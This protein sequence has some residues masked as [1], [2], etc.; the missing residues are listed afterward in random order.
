MG[1][2]LGTPSRKVASSRARSDREAQ[3]EMDGFYS[4]P[5]DT[6][7]GL[8]YLLLPSVSANDVVSRDTSIVWSDL[9]S[10]QK[11]DE[12]KKQSSHWKTV[13]FAFGQTALSTEAQAVLREILAHLQ[14]D[15]AV[16]VYVVGHSDNL[17]EE[18]VN[19]RVS[20]YRAE[21]VKQWLVDRGIDESRLHTVGK[22]SEEPTADN[23]STEGR[24]RNRRVEFWKK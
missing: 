2:I 9:T 1:F 21:L 22:G 11:S 10:E 17:G 23:G 13:G 19:K 14:K 7:A 5:P 18:S 20:A 3:R 4:Y 16:T 24:A 12:I 15:V 6:S 8:N